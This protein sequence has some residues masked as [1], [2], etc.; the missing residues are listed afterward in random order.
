LEKSVLGNRT[1]FIHTEGIH[2]QL[3]YRICISTGLN[4]ATVK[5]V[6]K[7]CV[8]R[9]V[10]ECLHLIFWPGIQRR[11][12]CHTAKQEPHWRMKIDRVLELVS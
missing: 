11:L 2:Y 10:V 6:R 7:F 5:N 3:S 8:T 9:E 12:H 4:K 1:H